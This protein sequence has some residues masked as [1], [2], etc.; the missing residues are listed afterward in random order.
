MS[1]TQVRVF[2]RV[3]KPGKVK[4]AMTYCLNTQEPNTKY[5][6][7]FAS[8]MQSDRWYKC[9]IKLHMYKEKESDQLDIITITH[10][11]T[12]KTDIIEYG[13]QIQAIINEY[14]E[15]GFYDPNASTVRVTIGDKPK[16]LE[17]KDEE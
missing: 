16:C 15:Y 5:I 13:R 6:G 9:V 10:F 4:P 17:H 2:G 12:Y 3:S 8:M 7:N 1:R 14:L 11:S